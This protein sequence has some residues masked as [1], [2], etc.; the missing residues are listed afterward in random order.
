[1]RTLSFAEKL[2]IALDFLKTNIAFFATPLWNQYHFKSWAQNV[3]IV[4]EFSQAM[5]GAMNDINEYK[6]AIIGKG[7]LD[8]HNSLLYGND[9]R[10]KYLLATNEKIVEVL[11]K[12]SK[13]KSLISAW[14]NYPGSIPKQKGKAD[15]EVLSNI[16]NRLQAKEKER[17]SRLV[18][19]TL[20]SKIEAKLDR[21]TESKSEASTHVA[22]TPSQIESIVPQSYDPIVASAGSKTISYQSMSTGKLSAPGLKKICRKFVGFGAG[23]EEFSKIVL[24]F[25][26][27]VAAL[28]FRKALWDKCEAEKIHSINVHIYETFNKKTYP[29]EF[30]L[31]VIAMAN[32]QVDRAISQDSQIAGSIM[33]AELEKL[34]SIENIP[35]LDTNYRCE[36]KVSP[37]ISK[38]P[39]IIV[40][41]NK[42]TIPKKL[43][44]PGLKKICKKL[45]K[46][47]TDSL[48]FYGISLVFENEKS[49]LA[50]RQALLDKC[51]AEKIYSINVDYNYGLLNE[52]T[53]TTEYIFKVVLR[54]NS[55]PYFDPS[56]K[57]TT[58]GEIML[59]ELARLV[60][61]KNIPQ[62]YTDY[63]H[64]PLAEPDTIK[65][66][67]MVKRAL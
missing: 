63:R 33:L 67:S 12:F 44:A 38:T 14:N 20:R 17:E 22:M 11:Y 21:V 42:N 48:E 7:N 36:P 50:F 32:S 30:M 26:S 40:T 10:I 15:Q 55:K 57:V 45:G 18:N 65:T 60:E 61:I 13:D 39:A 23:E 41:Q 64:K 35:Q 51:E 24:V 37:V 19:L 5:L 6:A 53:D 16:L 1:M 58:E 59:A 49:A 9:A 54:I 29:T 52:K 4:I 62:E 8:R 47:S 66:V 34:V 25:E 31:E 3:D 27:E 56:K 46:F 28:V 43:V 2:Q